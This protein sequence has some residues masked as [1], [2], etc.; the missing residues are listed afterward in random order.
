MIRLP[1]LLDSAQR[2]KARLQP[3]KLSLHLSL[4][5]LSAAEMV[6]PWDAPVIGPRDLIELY[7]ENGSAGI[8]HDFRLMASKKGWYFIRRDIVQ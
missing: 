4:T 2:E 7:D 8:F 3:V 6:L 1:R 5:P